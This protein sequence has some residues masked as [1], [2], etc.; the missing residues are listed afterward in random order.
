[1]NL[2][3]RH[4]ARPVHS[5]DEISLLHERFPDKIV[6]VT[7]TVGGALA[8]GA[9]LFAMGPVLRMQYTAT[10]PGGRAASATDPVIEHAIQLACQRGCAFFDFGG[11]TRDEGRD[12]SQDLYYFKASFGG[13]GVVY[14]QFEYDL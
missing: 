13:G 14:E 12:L 8:G 3:T 1:M 7:A 10:G 9:L 5:L 11:C 4:G 2:A 6:L